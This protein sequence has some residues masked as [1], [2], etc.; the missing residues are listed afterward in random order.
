MPQIYVQVSQGQIRI[1]QIEQTLCVVFL[2]KAQMY[3][4]LFLKLFKFKCRCD[5]KLTI[6]CY[7]SPYL[8]HNLKR[9]RLV[10]IQRL[11]SS[12]QE[13]VKKSEEV[14]QSYSF[15]LIK[16]KQVVLLPSAE[17]K[18]KCGTIFGKGRFLLHSCSQAVIISDSFVK[19]F[20]PPTYPSNF[21]IRV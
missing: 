12:T 6:I 19:K 14:K 5:E 4:V 9:N 3:C 10:L 13:E 11:Y 8:N 21:L 17:V 15:L 1:C 2:Y 16:E 7:I 20:K 18:F